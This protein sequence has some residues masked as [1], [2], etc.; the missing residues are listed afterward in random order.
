MNP[1]LPLDTLPTFR[2]VAQAGSMRAAAEGLHLTH[3]AISQQIRLL[4]QR[5]GFA[6]FQRE[7]RR[8]RLTEAGQGM[9]AAT[10]ACLTQLE[11]ARQDA[12]ARASGRIERLRLATVPSL[13]QRWLLPRIARWRAAHPDIHLELVASQA[14]ADLPREGLHAAIRLG[15]GHWRGLQAEPLVKSARVVVGSPAAAHRLAGQPTAALANEPLLGNAALWAQW[16]AGA[17]APRRVAP[18][19]AFNDAA[20]LLQAVESDIGLGLVRE[21]LAA[22]ALLQG[23][24]VR[25]HPHAL[26]ES[27][28]PQDPAVLWFAWRTDLQDW[29]PLQALRDWLRDE[30]AQSQ[31]ALAEH[32]ARGLAN[33]PTLPA[34]GDKP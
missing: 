14:V 11:R 24:L 20:L 29:P 17:D 23:Q 1:R 8:L 12:A 32:A 4:E 31:Q 34:Q 19:A 21:V 13:A 7:G 27:A 15:D 25:L 22:D 18:V 3:S 30:L 16:F 10:E 6:L 9:L 26:P 5:L 28:Q 33:P 2:A